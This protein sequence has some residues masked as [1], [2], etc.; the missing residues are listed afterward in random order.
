MI[1]ELVSRFE[2]LLTASAFDGKPWDRI[3]GVRCFILAG[4]F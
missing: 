3:E 1:M 2:Q 4:R